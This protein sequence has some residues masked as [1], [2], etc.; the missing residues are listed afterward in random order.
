MQEAQTRA[1]RS[2]IAYGIALKVS[3]GPSTCV[4]QIVSTGDRHY[5]QGRD[6]KCREEVINLR[7]SRLQIRE[8]QQRVQ[9]P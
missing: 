4:G 8:R 5:G 3:R 1:Q 9:K 6:R 2:Y 7:S